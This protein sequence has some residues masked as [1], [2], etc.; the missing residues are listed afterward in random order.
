IVLHITNRIIAAYITSHVRLLSWVIIHPQTWAESSR[1]WHRIP[2]CL[3]IPMEMYPWPGASARESRPCSVPARPALSA[4]AASGA[5]PAPRAPP[6]VW[7]LLPLG[8]S[9]PY[10]CRTPAAGRIPSDRPPADACF[11]HWL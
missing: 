5:G 6:A 2:S 7:S 11:L 1:Y 8:T 10:P 3:V 9:L 4:S